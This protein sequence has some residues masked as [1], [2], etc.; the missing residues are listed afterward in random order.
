M[1]LKNKTIQTSSKKEKE[2]EKYELELEKQNEQNK[3]ERFKTSGVPERF[4][5]ESFSTFYPRNSDEEKK[6]E[7]AKKY[8]QIKTDIV[9]LFTGNAGTGKT[10]LGS[11]IIREKGGSYYY[12][13]DLVIKFM[14]TFDFNSKVSTDDFLNKICSIETLVIDEIGRTTN[15]KKEQELLRLVLC[16]RY[17][18]S[19]RSG[20]ELHPLETAE[21]HFAAP[22]KAFR[23]AILVKKAS[24][25]GQNGF[26]TKWNL[27]L[28]LFP[29]LRPS[30]T[31]MDQSVSLYWISNHR[32]AVGLLL[33]SNE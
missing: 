5:N 1:N 9:L 32:I 26:L 19:L 31:W 23:I 24:P 29:P 16:R 2:V 27:I 10:H 22:P 18:H 13:Q 12:S 28:R 25:H 6:L 14:A 20:K 11:A 3:I 8:S 4:W 7:L 30:F 17:D 33:I 15:M 21:G